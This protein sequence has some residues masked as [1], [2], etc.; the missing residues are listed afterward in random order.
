[1]NI[2]QEME[3][4]T[5]AIMSMMDMAVS[6]LKVPVNDAE[7]FKRTLIITDFIRNKYGGF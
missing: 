5:I 1:M 7:G 6:T 4:L 2:T 3:I